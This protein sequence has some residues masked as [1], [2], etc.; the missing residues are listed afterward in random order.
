MV[1]IRNIELLREFSNII[2]AKGESLPEEVEGTVLALTKELPART[3]RVRYVAQTIGSDAIIATVP[4]NKIWRL[5][6]FW[7]DMSATAGVGN[8]LIGYRHRDAA[9]ATIMQFHPAVTMTA[10]LTRAFLGSENIPYALNNTTHHLAFPKT[11]LRAGEDLTLRDLAT[12][13]AADVANIAVFNFIEWD[14]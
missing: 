13:D 2:E 1:E 3:V 11:Y 4:A 12:I 7:A 10:N 5:I 8:R 6:G 14:V 9:G